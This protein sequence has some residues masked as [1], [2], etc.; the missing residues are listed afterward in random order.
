MLTSDNLSYTY[1]FANAAGASLSDLDVIVTCTITLVILVA[2]FV[3]LEALA[4]FTDS[5]T[6][7]QAKGISKSRGEVEA[8]KRELAQTKTTI[9][10]MERDNQ[11]DRD[12]FEKQ[13]HDVV[14]LL[15]KMQERQNSFSND[16]T[17]IETSLTSFK[18][19]QDVLF[20]HFKE[21]QDVLFDKQDKIYDLLME[22]KNAK[23]GKS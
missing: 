13:L 18:D 21:G 8:L 10:S 15:R 20:K 9:S 22:Q 1:P 3:R 17:A 5:E 12:T 14:E 16:L 19:S 23:G 11:R 7:S 6:K 4:K 2:W